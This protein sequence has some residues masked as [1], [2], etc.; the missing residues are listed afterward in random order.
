MSFIVQIN[1]IIIHLIFGDFLFFIYRSQVM[2]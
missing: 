1:L 2:Y